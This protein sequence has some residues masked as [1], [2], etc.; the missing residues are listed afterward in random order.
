MTG[1][2]TGSG[3]RQR[4]CELLDGAVVN[5]PSSLARESDFLADLIEGHLPLLSKTNHST[6]DGFVTRHNSDF[7]GGDISLSM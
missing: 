7:N 4:N 5:L 1:G 3:L 6:V 2:G